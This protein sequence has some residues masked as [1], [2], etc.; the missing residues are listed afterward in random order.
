MKPTPTERDNLVQDL[1]AAR[2]EAKVSVCAVARRAGVTDNAIHHVEKRGAHPSEKMLRAYA[3]LC[4][5][6]VD[7]VLLA[8]DIVPEADRAKLRANP[9]LLQMVRA[10]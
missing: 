5:M 2:V 8:W 9:Q 10:A 3:A 4:G 6:D 1:I 7:A